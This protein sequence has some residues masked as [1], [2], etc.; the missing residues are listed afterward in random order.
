MPVLGVCGDN[1]SECPRFI[2]TQSGDR[3]KLAALAALWVK[4]GIRDELPEPEEMACRGCTPENQC[5]YA[6]QR[7]C[8]LERGFANCG[9]CIEYPCD[10]AIE[11]LERSDAL[12]RR[13][14]A[15]CSAEEYDVLYKAFFSKRQNLT[16]R[17]G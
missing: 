4:V 9:D 3:S 12:A 6:D 13:C 11:G 8:A 1:C 2:A 14:R 5:A 17:G 7:R 15:S 16:F 10:I